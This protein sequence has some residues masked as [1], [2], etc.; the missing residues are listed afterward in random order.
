M[1]G[2]DTT[3]GLPHKLKGELADL[4]IIPDETYPSMLRRLIADHKRI[5][6]IKSIISGEE[7]SEKMIEEIKK[8]MEG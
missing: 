8:I 5:V 1:G 4:K 7:D 2:Y 6:N 3:I